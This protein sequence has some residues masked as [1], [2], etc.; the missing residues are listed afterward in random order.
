MLGEK[1]VAECV[2]C[3]V[4]VNTLER[5]L[6]FVRRSSLSSL[7]RNAGEVRALVIA[8]QL[9]VNGRASSAMLSCGE[10]QQKL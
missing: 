6:R 8:Q 9:Q 1:E 3:Y 4:M 7:A 2:K 10:G 5:M